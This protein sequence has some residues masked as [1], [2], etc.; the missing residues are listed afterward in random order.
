M[1]DKDSPVWASDHLAVVID[2]ALS[3]V[4]SNQE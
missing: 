2:F 4:T 1:L 3:S